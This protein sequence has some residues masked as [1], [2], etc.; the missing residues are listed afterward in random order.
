M[1]LTFDILKSRNS[2]KYDEKHLLSLNVRKIH[3]TFE[4]LQLFPFIVR[5]IEGDISSQRPVLI[6]VLIDKLELR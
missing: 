5:H 1:R 4:F 3:Q 6:D 2:T